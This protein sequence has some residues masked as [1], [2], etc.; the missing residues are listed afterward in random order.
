MAN[1]KRLSKSIVSGVFDATAVHSTIF[2]RPK[3]SKLVA[4]SRVSK[5][6][7]SVE[8]ALKSD[9]QAIGGD[10]KLAIAKY[11]VKHEQKQPN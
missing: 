5:P 7:P 1:L 4:V 2:D 11:A 8:D 6:L 3:F 9:W 10:I